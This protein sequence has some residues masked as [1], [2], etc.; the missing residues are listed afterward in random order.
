[1][2]ESYFGLSQRPFASV[3]CVE[4]Y[5]PT[6]SVEAARKTLTRCVERAE[7]VGLIV[8]PSGTGKTLLCRVLAAQFRGPFEV[9]LLRSGRLGAR[10][11]LLQAILYEL[12]LPYRG[13]D[14]GEL[15]LSLTEHLTSTD[16]SPQGMVLLVD[17]AQTLPLRLL[18]EVSA[19][20]N[21][22]HEDQPRVRLIVAGNRLLEERFAS[23]KLESLSQRVVARCYLESLNRT[24][25]QEYIHALVAAAG[26]KG[27][28]LFPAESC[29]SV[30]KATD[31]VPRLI[32][33][34]CDHALLLA[35]AGGKRQVEP[36]LVEEAWADL[37]QLPTPWN[38]QSDSDRNIIEFGGLEDEPA[39]AAKADAAAAKAPEAEPTAS[40]SPAADAA[41]AEAKAD[42]DAEASSPSLHVV[43]EIDESEA[44]ELEPTEQ[45]QRI[46]RM[47][48]DVEQEFCPAGTIGPEVELVFDEPEHPFRESFEEEEVI[49]DRYATRGEAIA[50]SPGEAGPAGAADSPAEQS[51]AASP[52][53]DLSAAT[54]EAAAA[55]QGP[56]DFGFPREVAEDESAAAA[57]TPT[58]PWGEVPSLAWGLSEEAPAP[59]KTAVGEEAPFSWENTE[60]TVVSSVALHKGTVPDQPSVGA[61]SDENRDSPQPIDS[62]VLESAGPPRSHRFDRLFANLRREERA[63]R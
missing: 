9:A 25:T 15:R 16:K 36:A 47:L 52:P 59:R 38:E 62:P 18:D 31:G 26:A 58:E 14:E 2:Y 35:C 10:R 3:P 27:P 12:G 63:R 33:Q 53:A 4:H 37:Q 20:T 5:F 51:E 8:G 55:S 40:D 22:V 39:D 7:G 30:Y 6:A 41:Q 48:A 60:T 43:P 54:E 21:L 29:N 49:R 45:L 56:Q 46:Q 24:E 50:A 34:V 19:L 13:M 28:R 57:E 44:A 23:P 42:A 17:E 11:A 61:R 1:M 32:N